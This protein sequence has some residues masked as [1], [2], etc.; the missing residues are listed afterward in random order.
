MNAAQPKQ[1]L[2]CWMDLKDRAAMEGGAQRV[3]L[4]HGWEYHLFPEAILSNYMT[5]TG[6]NN[7]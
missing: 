3:I 4:D 6:V 5:F 1:G 7:V 2:C